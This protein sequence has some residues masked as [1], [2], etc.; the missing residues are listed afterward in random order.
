MMET[1]A[2]DTLQQFVTAPVRTATYK[3]LLY[4]LLA[5][6]LG[7][8]YYVAFTTGSS[9]GLGLAFT[10]VGLP[11]LL[12]TLVATTGAAGLEARLATVL[13]DQA[14]ATRPSPRGTRGSEHCSSRGFLPLNRPR[15]E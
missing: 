14:V 5:F 10:L 15:G 6:P 1:T 2:G 8:A 11:V 9:L 4:L 12:V 3:R 13:L 7:V